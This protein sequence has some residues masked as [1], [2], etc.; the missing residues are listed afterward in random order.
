MCVIAKT[1]EDIDKLAATASHVEYPC[2]R[3]G[4][5]FNDGLKRLGSRP[6]QSYEIRDFVINAIEPW[7]QRAKTQRRRIKVVQ[8]VGTYIRWNFYNL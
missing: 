8:V 7:F 2:A 1:T 6:N 3:P 4:L 5:G